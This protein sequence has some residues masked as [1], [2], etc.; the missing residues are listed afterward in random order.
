MVRSTGVGSPHPGRVSTGIDPKGPLHCGL[1][2]LSEAL[3][4]IQ[5]LVALSPPEAQNRKWDLDAVFTSKEGGEDDFP[6]L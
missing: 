3:T 2:H 1:Y 4:D 5:F 6:Q